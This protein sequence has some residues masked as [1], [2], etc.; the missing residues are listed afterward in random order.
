MREKLIWLTVCAILSGA[1]WVVIESLKYV[2]LFIADH[3]RI[4]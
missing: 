2:G 3:V 1:G 4:Y